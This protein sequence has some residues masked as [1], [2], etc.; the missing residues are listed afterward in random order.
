MK[1]T[2]VYF[3]FLICIIATTNVQAQERDDVGHRVT[4]WNIS[5]HGC[6]KG[7]VWKLRKSYYSDN[8]DA[9]TNEIEIQNTYG[10]TITF[11]YN[12]SENSGETNTR[13]KKTLGPN[14]TYRS[15]Y[16]PN[17]HLVTFYVTDVCFLDNCKSDCFALCDNG[18]PN[19]PNCGSGSANPTYSNNKITT[20]KS[21]T[22]QPNQTTN[23]S[24]SQPTKTQS[25]TEPINQISNS[26]IDFAKA[27]DAA[28]E[29]KRQQ[30]EQERLEQER[31]QQQKKAEADMVIK[32]MEGQWKY[33]NEY[34][35]LNSDEG[36]Q[37]AI[38]LMLPYANAKKLNGGEL[39]TIGFWYWKIKDYKNAKKW[40][41]EAYYKK[42]AEG[43]RNLGVLALNGMGQKTDTV[44]AIH[45]FQEACDLGLEV[46][47]GEYK[48]FRNQLEILIEEKQ[49]KS[50]FVL[51]TVA[52]SYFKEK[53]YYMAAKY[54]SQFNDSVTD[55][56]F[57]METTLK[58]ADM[59]FDKS[60][61]NNYDSAAK[62]YDITINL[63]ENYSKE[64]ED[65]KTSEWR[66]KKYQKILL[67]YAYSTRYTNGKLAI[68]T[69]LKKDS[70]RF[71]GNVNYSSDERYLFYGTNTQIGQIYEYGFGGVEKD[72]KLAQSYY[73]KDAQIFKSAVAMN[74]LGHLFE[75]G[76][77]NLEQDKKESKNWYKMA[78]KTD[79]KYCK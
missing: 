62:Y 15:T 70:I 78:C 65:I 58:L 22:S 57:K 16:C 41:E 31:I 34:A 35:N 60:Q 33:A 52:E 75:I 76:G 29:A 30:R 17:V 19:Q 46:A 66:F 54:Y 40:Y 77:P 24:S 23:Y 69:Y 13:Y 74:Y 47:C 63:M 48:N 14:E 7:L 37:K 56:Y 21:N 61:L 53:D 10:T 36:Y 73:F 8:S 79:N 18:V 64:N 1:K 72:W 26:I 39:N 20:A 45:Y 59:Y 6:F 11:S 27:I 50:Y 9:Y 55:A 32:E 67:N 25:Q 49:M 42:N 51:Q 43:A 68:D 2:L 28:Q 44:W 12:M 71:K 3:T 38:E 4:A 5:K